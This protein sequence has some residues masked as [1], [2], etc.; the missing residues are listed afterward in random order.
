MTDKSELVELIGNLELAVIPKFV[1]CSQS[2]NAGEKMPS[3][4]W[5][6]TLQCRGRD[7]FTVDY[8]AGMGHAPSYKNWKSGGSALQ[9]DA[10]VFECENGRPARIAPG[11]TV[12]ADARQTILPDTIDVIYSL[13]S[14]ADAIEYPSFEDWASNFG[15]EPDSRKAEKI[16]RQCLEIGLALRSALGEA[17]LLKLREAFQDY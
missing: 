17:N 4:N 16:Y 7:L 6:I 12:Y 3:L 5:K 8:N 13:V 10:I 14:D 11:G 9:H 15:Y 2:R 1:P